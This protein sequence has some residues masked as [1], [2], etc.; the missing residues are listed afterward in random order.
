LI[1]LYCFWDPDQ[2]AGF[3]SSIIFIRNNHKVKQIQVLEIGKETAMID[4]FRSDLKYSFGTTFVYFSLKK[5]NFFQKGF[6]S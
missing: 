3:V 1:N 2:G 6:L 5:K 4:W